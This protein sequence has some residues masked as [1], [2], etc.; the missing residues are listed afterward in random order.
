M[1]TIYVYAEHTTQAGEVCPDPHSHYEDPDETPDLI[2]WRGTEEEMRAMAEMA[3]SLEPTARN[4]FPRR[5]GK[6]VLGNLP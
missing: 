6:S 3:L 5:V 1:Q 4:A 2:I